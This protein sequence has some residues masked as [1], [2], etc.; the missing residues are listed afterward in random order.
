MYHIVYE[1][2]GKCILYDA[3]VREYSQDVQDVRNI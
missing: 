3:L 1:N 2:D